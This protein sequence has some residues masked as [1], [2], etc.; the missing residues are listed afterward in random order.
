[1]KSLRR[2]LGPAAPTYPHARSAHNRGISAEPKATIEIQVQYE[3]ISGCRRVTLLY[4]ISAEKILWLQTG[5]SFMFDLKHKRF[6]GYV[7]EILSCLVR[8]R[9]GAFGFSLILAF[10]RFAHVERQGCRP[11]TCLGTLSPDPFLASR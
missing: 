6:S 2:G 7:R 9:I 1:M 4:L 8:I 11:E 10:L 3:R 5:N